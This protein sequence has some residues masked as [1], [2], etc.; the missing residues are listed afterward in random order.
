MLEIEAFTGANVPLKAG[1][2]QTITVNNRWDQQDCL[3]K[4][5]SCVQ[6]QAGSYTVVA[7]W[8]WSDGGTYWGSTAFSL[9]G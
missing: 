5:S 4:N 7:E 6:A 1:P 2:G 8:H 3:V 9:G